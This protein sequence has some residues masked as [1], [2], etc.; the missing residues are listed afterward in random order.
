MGEEKNMIKKLSRV[1]VSSE[2]G[3]QT[4]RPASNEEIM[5]K[6]NEI[7]N[8]LNKTSEINPFVSTQSF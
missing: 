5:D 1:I 3:L 8:K 4:S 2:N 6:I 7:I